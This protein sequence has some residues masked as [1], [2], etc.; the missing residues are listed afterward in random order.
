MSLSNIP[1][2]ERPHIA[3]FG[4]RNAG[5]SS[6]VNAVTG[7]NLSIVSDKLGTTT[8]P[9]SKAMEILPLGPVVIIDT[10]GFDDEGEIGELRVEKTQEVL[11]RT[12]LAVLVV[13]ITK[14]FRQCDKAL[15]SLF[16]EKSIP[17]ITVMNKADLNNVDSEKT[18]LNKAAQEDGGSNKSAESAKE[19]PSKA[20]IFVSAKT[21]DGI[22]ELKEAIGHLLDKNKA[23]K[24]VVRDLIKPNDLVVL[25]IPIDESAPKDRIILPQQMV[26]REC[27]DGKAAAL[28]VQPEELA[29]LLKALSRKPILVI[30][31]SQAFKEAAQDTPSDIYLTSFSILM[32]RYKGFLETAVKGVSIIKNLQ[33]GA[34]VLIAE[35]CTHHRQCNDIGTVKLPKLLKAFT[36]KALVY[37]TCS[38]REFPFDLSSY[39][40]V[41]HCGGCMVTETEML[42]RMKQAVEQGIPFTNYG[43]MLAYLNG[44]LIRSLEM[45]PEIKALL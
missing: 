27:L 17:F 1:S 24:Y 19:K 6:V 26:L 34:R 3:F 39:D 31:D 5:K 4:M 11:R 15:M 20:M 43:I 29:S 7:Q 25:V 40:L 8:D 30:T 32:A 33:D 28:C 10:P 22:H 35:G 2:S 42:N 16:R 9:V 38:G 21:G 12:D 36:G 45:F 18:D 41:L 13:D 14:G 37:E 23:L 44:I